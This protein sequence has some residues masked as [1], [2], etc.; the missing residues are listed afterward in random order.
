MIDLAPVFPLPNAVLFPDTV[1]PLH[2]F[3]PRY[4]QMIRDASGGDGHVAIALLEP[5]FEDDYDGSP[6]FHRVG[7]L[8]R[9]ENLESLSDGRFNLHL[10]GLRRVEFEEI[11]APTPYRVARLIARN[12][13]GVSDGD[14]EIVRAKLDLLASHAFLVQQVAGET[15]SSL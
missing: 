3:E 1:L 6:A 12:E 7:T 5:G 8:G 15:A 2:I 9:I 4:R 14:P 11:P 10:I 13:T